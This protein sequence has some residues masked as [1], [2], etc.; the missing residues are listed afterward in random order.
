MRIKILLFFGLLLMAN[1]LSAQRK[2]EA[3]DRGLVAVQSSEGIFVS[4]RILG[5]E[6]YG[7][8]YNLY[9]NGEKLNTEPLEVS[10][11]LD[12]SGSLS[13][14]Y[15]V[16]AIVNG[17]EEPPS[18]SV[19]PLSEQYLEIPLVSRP[20]G[21]EPNDATTADLDGDGEY[22]IILKRIINDWSEEA[23]QFAYFE[24]YKMDGTLMWDINVGPNI[25]SSSAVEINIA[26][27]DF[28]EDG[29]AE[30]FLRTSEGTIFGDGT[31]IG[32]TDGDGKTN[33]RY[34]VVQSPNMQYMNEGP[35]FLSLV[36]GETGVELDR[37]D[38]IPRGKSSDWGD[39]YGHRANKFFFGAPYLDGKKPSLFIGRGIYTK[40]EMRTYDVVNKELVLRWEFSSED[41][42]GYGGQGNHNMTIADVDEDG[43]DEIVY[44]S[45]TVDDDGSGLYSTELGHGDA[46]HVGDLD[47]F[48]KG[49]EVWRC[50]ENSPM[51]GTVYHD[52]ATG[53]ILIHDVLG[54]DCGR[55]MAANISDEVM[56]ATLWGSTT[57]FS[58][59]TKAPVSLE[60]NSVNFRI[61]WDGDLLEELL[62]HN[63]NGSGGEGVIQKS[64]HGNIF[65]ATG[66]NSN[67]WTKGTPALQADLF[68]DWREEVIW[69][70]TDN[71]KI[72]IYTTVDPTPFRVYT[73][74]HDHQY[75]QAICWQMCGYNQ[76]P[77]TSFFLGEREGIT[78]PPPPMITNGRLV[79]NGGGVWD[80][81]SANWLRDG[82]VSTF[83]DG[84]QVLFDVSNGENVTLDLSETV[85]P[86]NLTVNS[87]GNYTLNTSTGKFSGNMHL[88][89][90][91]SGT[92]SVEGTHDFSGE[93]KV[94]NGRLALDGNLTNSPVLV[95]LFAELAAKGQL[96]KG[97]NMRQGSSLFVGGIRCLAIWI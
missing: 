71:K 48:R 68:G 73:L 93:T 8:T 22:E 86:S 29:K 80:K 45:M 69:R 46:M 6:W 16:K 10:N 63:W 23:T 64:G 84:D 24:A 40:T 81:T 38:F 82:Q 52:G 14:T 51:Y 77:H 72:R 25:M 87:S 44:G 30:V 20:D 67:N 75:R 90:Q 4:W 62:D 15:S 39:S 88:T 35:E 70:T 97:V 92:F 7:V 78:V 17:E 36:D 56:G 85:S 19:Q 50:L 1:A 43:R 96:G 3:L 2:M 55:A 47:P 9:R 74:M 53:E 28:N 41:N 76:P 11:Y 13:S 18:K 59:T 33:Y 34:S 37:V 21:Y 32:D 12:D 42:P 61:Y 65:T 49:I 94:W 66:T 26:A 54:R 89:K 5:E 27:F 95:N 79:Y 60:T 83:E 31:K 91:G 58:A 57:K